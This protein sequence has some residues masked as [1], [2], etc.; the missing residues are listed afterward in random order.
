MKEAWTNAEKLALVEAYLNQGLRLERVAKTFGLNTSTVRSWLRAY[1]TGLLG[2]TPRVFLTVQLDESWL[3]ALEELRKEV[4]LDAWVL[5]LVYNELS[6]T[7]GLPRESSLPGLELRLGLLPRGEKG[8]RWTPEGR[9]TLVSAIL[10][11][12]LDLSA[13]CYEF[14]LDPEELARWVDRHSQLERK[15]CHL[16]LEPELVARI[17]RRCTNASDKRSPELLAGWVREL[18]AREL[19]I[20]GAVPSRPAPDFRPY[21]GR[22]RTS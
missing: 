4:S 3:D 16:V 2:V 19:G 13:A 11:G 15:R 1:Q 9:T 22:K 12:R 21:G 14:D 17:K 8:R 20:E 18:V 7:A 5:Q 10:S 6:Y